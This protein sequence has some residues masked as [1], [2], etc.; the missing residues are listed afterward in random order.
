[1]KQWRRLTHSHRA[2]ST[3]SPPLGNQPVDPLQAALETCTGARPV[4]TLTRTGNV[5]CTPISQLPITHS[6]AIS[7]RPWQTPDKTVLATRACVPVVDSN[8]LRTELPGRSAPPEI[9]RH[10]SPHQPRISVRPIIYAFSAK[11]G[12]AGIRSDG[13]N[14][15]RTGPAETVS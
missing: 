3:S 10:L 7:R 4:I 12:S 1:M 15:L 8:T 6:R 13:L 11:R 5:A 9:S 14:N 2:S